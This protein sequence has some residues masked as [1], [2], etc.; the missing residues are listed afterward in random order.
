M[1]N[2]SD[3]TQFHTSVGAQN[4]ERQNV[5][6]PIFRNCEIA[7]IKITKDKLND[8]FIFEIIFFIFEKLFTR[9]IF[10]SF[11]N[12]KIFIFQMVNF[13]SYFSNC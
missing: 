5:V 3:L 7:N 2:K 6:R 8:S 10:N 9:K 4:L 1:S 12:Y 11:S 13:F